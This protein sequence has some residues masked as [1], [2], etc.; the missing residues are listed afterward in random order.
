MRRTAHQALLSVASSIQR[1]ESKITAFEIGDDVSHGGR[2][3]SFGQPVEERSA[4][5]PQDFRPNIPQKK[6]PKQ[7][8]R[9][10]QQQRP[11]AYFV[12]DRLLVFSPG[13][14]ARFSRIDLSRYGL[15]IAQA[16]I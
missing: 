6:A 13:R 5:I 15:V 16:C 2:D 7:G 4:V 8:F 11:T 14:Q 1:T 12:G 9:G 10:Y 3:V